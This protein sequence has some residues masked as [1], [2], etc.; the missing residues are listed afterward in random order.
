MKA[1]AWIDQVK[2][3][4]NLPSD[5]AAAKAIGVS[6]ALVSSYRGRI[7]TFD[8]DTA[9]KVADVLNINPAGVILDQAAERTKNPSV[10][11]LLSREVERLCILC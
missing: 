2:K 9:I 10:R 6:R 11:A 7:P 8:E 5:Y 1:S 3:T 4:L